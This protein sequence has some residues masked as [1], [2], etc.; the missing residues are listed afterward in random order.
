VLLVF[1]CIMI[2]L[3]LSLNLDN[4]PPDKNG[5]KDP[6]MFTLWEKFFYACDLLFLCDLIA[7]FF[8]TYIKEADSEVEEDNRCQIAKG[9]LKSW[10]FIDLVSII[11]FN[12]V[13]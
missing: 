9:Y 2:P 11:P 6:Y 4:H 3:R 10:F 1:V 7:Q 8:M 12:M 13:M 5:F